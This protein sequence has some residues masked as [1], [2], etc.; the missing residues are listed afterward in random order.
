[1]FFSLFLFSQVQGFKFFTPA[2]HEFCFSQDLDPGT[3]SV[4]SL[5][6]SAEVPF[7]I[8]DPNTEF[9]YSRAGTEHL[10]SF[11]A[12]EGGTFGYCIDNTIDNVVHIELDLKTGVNAKDYSGIASTKNLQAVEV[13]LRK[14]EDQTKGIHKKIQFLREREE[15]MRNTNTTIQNRVIGYSLCTVV[16]LVCLALI[17]ILYLK[18]F[19]RAKKMI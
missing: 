15:Q 13:K 11:T 16:M 9:L 8:V 12:L 2:K 18:R 17:Q 10:F 19:F 3:L 1:M 7:K 14:L 6:T 4:V 5:K